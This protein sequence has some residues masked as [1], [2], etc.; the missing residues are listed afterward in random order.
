MIPPRSL[1]LIVTDTSCSR[2]GHGWRESYPILRCNNG[3]LGGTPGERDK[4]LPIT[5]TRYRFH[6]AP[7]CHRCSQPQEIYHDYPAHQR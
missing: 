4:Q 1:Y 7:A 5:A 2:C 3:A 6:S